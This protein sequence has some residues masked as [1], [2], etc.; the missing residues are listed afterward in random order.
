MDALLRVVTTNGVPLAWN[1]D[2]ITLDPRLV[3]PAPSP[4]TYIVQLMGFK[5]PADAEVRFTGGDGCVY[6]LHLDATSSRPATR[7]EGVPES[8]PNDTFSQ[9]ALVTLPATLVG[10]IEAAGVED[11]FRFQAR[12]GEFIE[13]RVEAASLGSIL[14]A[15]VKFI[16]AEGKELDRNDDAEGSRDP[17][18]EW[19]VPTNGTYAAVVGSVLQQG[20]EAHWY[21]LTLRSASPD[22][23]A[24]LSSLALRVNAGET[25]E[26]KLI[27]KRLRGFD[28]KLKASLLG[29]P[30]GV[31][32]EVVE[33]GKKDGDAVFKVVASPGAPPWNGPIQ[34]EI[35]DSNTDEKRLATVLLTASTEDNGVPGGYTRLAINAMENFWL[36]VRAKPPG[37]SK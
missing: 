7:P 25:N 14:D 35:T 33:F 5:Y 15:W 12:K 21:R 23:R 10:D 9:A 11:C 3:W 2:F 37:K 18:L 36:T 19:K 31:T 32:A 20:G 29:L 8:E 4:G 6:R 26:L 17:R 34:V 30:E 28:H 13:A 1:H 24:T 22:Y 16:D 27:V